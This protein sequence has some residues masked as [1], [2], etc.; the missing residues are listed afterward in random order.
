VCKAV[1]TELNALVFPVVRRLLAKAPPDERELYAGASLI[2]LGG[3]VSHQSLGTIRH[4]LDRSDTFRKPLRTALPHDWRWLEGELPAQLEPIL[5]L[6]NPAAH[7]R[8]V[9]RE[10]MGRLRQSILGIGCEGLLVRIV[11]SK[12]RSRG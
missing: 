3:R 5:D 10:E 6:R 8:S 7:E 9:T 4:L 12:L 2:D 11:R 1:E